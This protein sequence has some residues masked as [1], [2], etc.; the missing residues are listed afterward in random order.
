M[1]GEAT[2]KFSWLWRGR[3]PWQRI[4]SSSA[5]NFFRSA[6]KEVDGAGR[7]PARGLSAGP[8]QTR[9]QPLGPDP[10]PCPQASAGHR[11]AVSPSLSMGHPEVPIRFKGEGMYFPHT[12]WDGSLGAKQERL[13]CLLRTGAS[14][15]SPR[16]A[17]KSPSYTPSSTAHTRAAGA[18]E[19]P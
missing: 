10:G 2:S 8:D 15:A 19:Q 14:A 17:V 13:R 7:R 16:R 6:S 5:G 1:V 12:S 4:F 9:L 11:T 3:W 18:H